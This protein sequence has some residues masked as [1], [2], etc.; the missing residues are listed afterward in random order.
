VER[1][2]IKEGN[3]NGNVTENGANA[4]RSGSSVLCVFQRPNYPS[5]MLRITVFLRCALT[6]TMPLPFNRKVH[7]RPDNLASAYF[8]LPY[9][10]HLLFIS[11]SIRTF[12]PCFY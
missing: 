3:G 9:L 6:I 12:P 1:G 4:K 8:L 10:K 2:Y 7:L 5:F 11:F